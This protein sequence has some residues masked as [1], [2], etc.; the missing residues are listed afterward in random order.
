M[1]PRLPQSRATKRP[2][3]PADHRGLAR[4]A[5]RVAIALL[6]IGGVVAWALAT[7]GV[8]S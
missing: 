7:G 5:L 8:V 6:G 3:H 4:M 1:T 2:P